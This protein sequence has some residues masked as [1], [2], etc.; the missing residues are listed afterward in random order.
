[1][2]LLALRPESAAVDIG[3]RMA[4][5]ANHRGFDDILGSDVAL[6]AADRGMRAGQWKTRA[7]GMIEVPQIPTIGGMAEAAFLAQ[8]AFMGVL[9]GVTA[10][11]ALG[12][13]AE[14]LVRVTLS[15]GHGDV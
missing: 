12:S 4:A 1:M 13:L 6:R 3:L 8:G 5:T 15:A 14:V 7:R 10:V 11:A 9:P 2:A